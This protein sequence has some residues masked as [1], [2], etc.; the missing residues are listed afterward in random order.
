MACKSSKLKQ[1][2]APRVVSFKAA[3]DKEAEARHA[4]AAAK[5]YLPLFDAMLARRK[6]DAA[7][8]LQSMVAENERLA[9][10]LTQ[11]LQTR[12]SPEGA[13][14]LARIEKQMAAQRRLTDRVLAET[15]MLCQ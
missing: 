1:Q 11:K 15:Q 4:T 8:K 2:R 13:R 12:P 9:A 6:A 3:G 5:R 10:E 7:A 14:Q